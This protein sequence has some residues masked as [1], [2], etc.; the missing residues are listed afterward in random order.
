VTRDRKIRSNSYSADRQSARRKH[1]LNLRGRALS[2]SS[3][4]SSSIINATGIRQRTT[5]SSSTGGDDGSSSSSSCSGGVGDIAGVSVDDMLL[6]PQ[7]DSPTDST[8]SSSGY[9]SLSGGLPF[10]KAW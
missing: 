6:H 8:D 4:S 10:K 3:S 5:R 2:I 1:V 9:D 7:V